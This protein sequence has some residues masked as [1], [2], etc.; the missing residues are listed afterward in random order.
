M[1]GLYTR[2]TEG[3]PDVAKYAY[4]VRSKTDVRTGPGPDAEPTGRVLEADQRI[5]VSERRTLEDAQTFLKLA[6]AAG[7]WVDAAAAE[8]VA[9][10]KPVAYEPITTFAFDWD[11]R[12]GRVTVYLTLPGVHELP[13]GSVQADFGE[14][15][16]DLRVHG[17]VNQRLLVPE[18][19][20]V[21]VPARCRCRVKKDKVVLL[22]K[23]GPPVVPSARGE[24]CRA[25]RPG[26]VGREPRAVSAWFFVVSLPAAIHLTSLPLASSRARKQIVHDVARRHCRAL[27]AGAAPSPQHRPRS[28]LFADLSIAARRSLSIKLFQWPG[29]RRSEAFR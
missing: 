17:G 29:V 9:L 7:G 11:D 8:E 24:A 21:I 18:L 10:P 20:D 16:L 26:R 23:T 22:L 1:S 27:A 28:L 12:K 13:E 19:Y 25:P 14:R 6:D 4:V 5:E 15:S 2:W 3:R